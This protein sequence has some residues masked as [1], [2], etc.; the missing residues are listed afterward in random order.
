MLDL[1]VGQV[2]SVI[3]VIVHVVKLFLPGAIVLIL[4]GIL[5]DENTAVTWSV[6]QRSRIARISPDG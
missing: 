4:A 2:S 3:A 1:S 5:K 6:V